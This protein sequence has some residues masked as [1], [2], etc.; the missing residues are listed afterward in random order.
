MS[1][2]ITELNEKL[3]EVI[4]KCP[5]ITYMGEEIL[6]QPAEE[7]ELAEVVD[8]ADKLQKTLLAYR[9]ITGLGR[10]LAAPQVGISKRVFVTYA[11]NVFKTYINP[12][13]LETSTEANM[14]RELCISC[15]YVSGDVKRPRSITI[16]Y[17]DEKGERQTEKADGFLARLL[18]HE[19]DHLEGILNLD[20]AEAGTVAFM[21]S[22]P[23]KEELREV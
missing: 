17:M 21:T 19:Y 12:I 8:I 7:V 5:E 6:R 14:F 9:G 15:G 20:K 18:Q 4:I 16:E 3:N 1:K 13:L 10:G 2:T 11:D 22:D 23:T